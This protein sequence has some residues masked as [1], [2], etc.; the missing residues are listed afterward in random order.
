MAP[1]AIGRKHLV[2]GAALILGS[3]SLAAHAD[4][5]LEQVVVT[6]TRTPTALPDVA[7]SVSVI[8]A[9]G[10]A[11][12]PAQELDDVLRLVPGVDLLG[13]SGDAQHP[14]SDSIG[15]RGLGGT[16]Q[17]ISRA[18]VMVDGIPINDPFFGYIQWGRIP[19]ENIERVEVVRGGG[20]P[21]WG[22]YAEGGVINVI[23]REPSAQQLTLGGG[24]GSYGTYRASAYG[25]YFPAEGNTLQAFGSLDGTGGFQQ[26]PTYER[27]PFNVPTSFH[28]ANIH[29]NGSLEPSDDLIAHVGLDYHD[30]H[31]RL[32]TVLD[33]NS[34]EIYTLTGDIQKSFSEG[35]SLAM[36]FA[37]SYPERTRALVLDSWI[38]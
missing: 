6:A 8:T 30:N 7:A 33:H 17:G 13:Y 21:L 25:A 31:Q 24:G 38:G 14:T 28:A 32:E 26:V 29:L 36:L 15:M 22:N 27:A 37:G 2:C 16:A 4:T 35:G 23:T 5:D 10:I 3:A 9:A 19:L 20:S 1:F 12:T 18:L 34:Q 11:N